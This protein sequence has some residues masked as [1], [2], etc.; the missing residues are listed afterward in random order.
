MKNLMNNI[1]Y[2]E[3]RFNIKL[4]FSK[5]KRVNDNKSNMIRYADSSVSSKSNDRTTPRVQEKN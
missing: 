4:M 1:K 3:L 2:F 5:V